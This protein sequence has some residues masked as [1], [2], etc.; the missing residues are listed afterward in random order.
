M[1]EENPRY[2]HEEQKSESFYD[3]PPDHPD[4]TLN[5]PIEDFEEFQNLMRIISEYKESSSSLTGEEED[6]MITE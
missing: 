5:K 1:E 4:V 2:K 6:A 3:F